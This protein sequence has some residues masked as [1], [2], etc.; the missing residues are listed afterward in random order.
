MA[1]IEIAGRTLVVHI[2]GVDRFLALQSRIEVPL[3]HIAAVEVNPQEAHAIFHGLRMGGT[4]V[5][6]VITAGRFLQHGGWAFWDVRDPSESILVRLHDEG[7]AKLVI[8]VDDPA[9]AARAIEAG[10]AA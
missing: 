1:E 9:A 4:N 3:E 2:R 5:P 6:G 7:Y 10:I 8:G